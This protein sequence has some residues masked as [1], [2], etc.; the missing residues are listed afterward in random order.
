M[1]SITTSAFKAISFEKRREILDGYSRDDETHRQAERPG[2]AAMG[3]T[4][5]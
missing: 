3:T 2:I 1:W 4:E 5:A